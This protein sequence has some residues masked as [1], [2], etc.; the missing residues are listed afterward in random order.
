MSN[1]MDDDVGSAIFLWETWKGAINIMEAVVKQKMRCITWFHN[2]SH[3]ESF[4]SNVCIRSQKRFGNLEKERQGKEIRMSFKRD[5]NKLIEKSKS[6]KVR[7]L[8]FQN[9]LQ[10]VEKSFF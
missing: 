7:I 2:G 6:L 1:E 10:H 4:R 8:I 9:N 5:E 3:G